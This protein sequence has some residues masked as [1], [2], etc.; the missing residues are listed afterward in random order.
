MVQSVK[1]SL[2]FTIPKLNVAGLGLSEL[3]Q[4]KIEGEEE[5]KQGKN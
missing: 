4:D 5:C 3:V 2:P 1:K